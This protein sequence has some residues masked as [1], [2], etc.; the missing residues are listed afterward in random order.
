MWLY[1][2]NS[3]LDCLVKGYLKVHLYFDI[4]IEYLSK[5]SNFKNFFM[6]K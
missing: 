4:F 3:L 1:A 5:M 2:A 6:N